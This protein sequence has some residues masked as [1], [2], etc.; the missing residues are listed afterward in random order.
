LPI[1]FLWAV[2]VVAASL[3]PVQDGPSVG[4]D[5]LLHFIAYFAL[6]GLV[7]ISTWSVRWCLFAVAFII[8]LGGVLE[9][10]QPHYGRA[11]DWLDFF[12]DAA[13]AV[14]GFLAAF[15]IRQVF[16]EGGRGAHQSALRPR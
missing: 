7:S 14:S 8:V 2:W 11:G 4:N 6:A 1:A 15:A 16:S 3:A 10:V 13:G 9:I 5:K 12:A